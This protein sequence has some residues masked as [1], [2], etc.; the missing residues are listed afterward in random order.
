MR[1]DSPTE[2][3]PTTGRCADVD[4]RA[5]R[6]GD[7][8][9]WVDAHG[10]ALFRYAL[11]RLSDRTTAEDLVQETFLAALEARERFRGASAPRTWLIS[12]LRHKLVDHLRRAG[13]QQIAGDAEVFESGV[14]TAFDARGRWIERPG[15]WAPQLP[16]SEL[17]RREFRQALQACAEGV[18][19][20]AREAFALRVLCDLSAEDVCK[21]LEIKPTNLWVLLHRARSRLRACLESTWFGRGPEDEPR[22]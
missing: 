22:C 5:E 21:V 1:P 19:G 9:L 3:H 12:V 8:S 7:P 20:R 6:A 18:A 14:E 11:S 16:A 13:R 10:D 4:P 15:R 17:E 2:Q